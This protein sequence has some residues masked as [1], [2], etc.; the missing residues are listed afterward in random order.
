VQDFAK[1][2]PLLQ[3]AADAGETVA[4]N[5]LATR[6]IFRS[7]FGHIVALALQFGL[8]AI[9]PLSGSHSD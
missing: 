2:L 3:K 5:N 4:M 7:I 8:L 6:M 9:N 1:A